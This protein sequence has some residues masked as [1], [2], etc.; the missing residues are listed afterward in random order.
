MPLKFAPL[1]VIAQLVVAPVFAQSD[2]ESHATTHV[3]GMTHD[4]MQTSETDVVLPTEPGQGA[5]AAISEIVTMLGAD[6]ATD[7]ATVDITGLRNHLVD[8]DGLVSESIITSREI[9]GGL[10]FSIDLGK[11][12]NQAASRMV[13]AHAPFVHAET[14]WSSLVSQDG[15]TLIWVVTSNPD[16]LQIRALGF[17]GLMATGDHHRAH[18]LAMA[19]GDIAH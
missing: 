18:H 17:F 9:P 19:R 16:A 6:P 12:G 10:E 3:P 7:W 15:D 11:S 13:P 8:M 1:I 5:F 4:G 2:S 14:G